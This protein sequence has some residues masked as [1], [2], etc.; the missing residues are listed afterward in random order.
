MHT[1]NFGEEVSRGRLCIIRECLGKKG[2]GLDGV[3]GRFRCF[4]QLVHLRG[5]VV[6]SKERGMT[7]RLVAYRKMKIC[8]RVQDAQF[9]LFFFH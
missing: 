2:M 8:A 5:R 6:L 4:C 9:F 3:D 7:R 1:R